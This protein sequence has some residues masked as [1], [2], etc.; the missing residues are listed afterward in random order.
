MSSSKL[1][2]SSIIVSIILAVGYLF[3]F[4]KES[5]IAN[6]FGV[7][8]DVDA[9]TIAIT[10]PVI[11]FSIVTV[12]IRSVIV[13]IYSD[14]FYN[15]TKEVADR[16]ISNVL[17]C[18]SIIICILIIILEFGAGYL[19]YLFAPGF[20]I[21]THDLSTFLLRITLPSIL[22]TV[23]NDILIG[24][25]NVHKRFIAPSCAIFCLNL[26]LILTVILLH[27]HYGITAAAL[28]Y[29]LG[30]GLSMLYVVKIASKVYRFHFVF[31]FKDALLRRT[32]KQ[33][34]PVVWSTSIA[35]I[36]A[37]LNRM[38]ASFLFVGSIS[39]LGY[40]NKINTIFISFFITAVATIVYPLY[41]ESSA[42]KDMNQLS[43]RINFTLSLYTMLL[44]PIV[45]GVLCFRKELVSVAFARG[46]F[47]AV[48]VES[49]A[50]LLGCYSLGLL[51]M[52]FRETLTK[53]FYSFQDMKTPA[54]NATIGV[55]LNIVLNITL[56]FIVGVEGL[57]LGTSF[58]A[59][60]IS[61]R[62]LFLLKKKYNQ[63]QLDYF[64]KNMIGILYSAFTM[65]VFIFSFLYF[66]DGTN[67]FITLFLGL[68]IGA[69]TYL[70]SLILF[71]VP[72]FKQAIQ[73]I[74][75]KSSRDSVCTDGV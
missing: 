36:N 49:T 28:G 47:D 22:F 44:I 71:Q 43:L 48:A 2:R 10:I 38:I 57:A 37:V 18:V 16:F 51:F 25:L 24:L 15:K 75:R 53:V 32:I 69:S 11:L 20:D 8:A 1:A 29:I 62:L 45:L 21:A 41:A 73:M 23:I 9:Y 6:Y 27:E 60:F 56:P 35:E 54:K 40:A 66:Y 64:Q 17:C 58:T 63:V 72:V 3:S 33:T 14:F 50:S 4:A 13:P 55:L 67:S 34:V 74:F 12:S 68:V 70:V 5:I 59:M 46:A 42:K 26:C 19:T 65:G 7:S 31:D 30:G 61:L 52:S 39:V